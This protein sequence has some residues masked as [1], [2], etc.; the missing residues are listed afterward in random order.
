MFHV[1]TVYDPDTG[2]W[3][4][5]VIDLTTGEKHPTELT[6]TQLQA[7][8]DAAVWIKDREMAPQCCGL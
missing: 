7:E 1:I 2:G 8:R 5:E 6:R 4:A 3:R